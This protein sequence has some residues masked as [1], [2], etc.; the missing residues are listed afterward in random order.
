MQQMA[1][2]L[3]KQKQI[4][5]L[6]TKQVQGNSASESSQLETDSNLSAPLAKSSQFSNLAEQLGKFIHEPIKDKTFTL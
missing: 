6:L 5:S 2:R 3:G 1:E 4:M